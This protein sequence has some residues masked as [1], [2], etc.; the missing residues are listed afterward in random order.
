MRHILVP[1]DFSEDSVHALENAIE[2]ANKLNANIRLIHVTKKNTAFNDVFNLKDC[3][4]A[5]SNSIEDYFDIIVKKYET[6]L[7]GTFDYKIREGK[8]Y[9]EINNQAKYDDAYM[10]VMGTHGMSGFEARWIGSNAFRVLVNSAC[11]VVTI[12]RGFEKI[13][14]KKIVIPLDPSCETRQKIPFVTNIAKEFGADIYLL[15]VRS[16]NN[17]SSIEKLEKYSSQAAE[18]I[19]NK[20]VKCIRES[21]VGNS[22][23]D[24]I[25]DFS[26]VIDAD[27]IAMMTE[28]SESAKKKFIGNYAQQM[29][30]H[31]PIP[32]IS[33]NPI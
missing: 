27:L 21:F 20:N 3:S 26:K 24:T 11:P 7:N 10:I 2:Y 25:I 16:S 17:N 22:L 6:K 4:K 8:V 18:Y 19:N 31:S 32:V 12:R 5:I 29:I 13:G 33:F 23:S 30:N 15:E 1:I 9:A 14:V 28:Q